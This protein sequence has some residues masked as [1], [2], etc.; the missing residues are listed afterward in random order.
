MTTDGTG[1]DDGISTGSTTTEPPFNCSDAGG[2]P[3]CVAYLYVDP[4][5]HPFFCTRLKIILVEAARP[6]L[7]P[8]SPPVRSL[9]VPL[10]VTEVQTAVTTPTTTTRR[11]LVGRPTCG[12][13]GKAIPV[14][15]VNL[16]AIAELQ[17]SEDGKASWTPTKI[18]LSGRIV[19]GEFVVGD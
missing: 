17:E 11:Q 7:T 2:G 6:N 12:S 1:D 10:T 19:N 13:G 8:V 3:H 15:G 9:T 18:R 16:D 5:G 4:D 14:V